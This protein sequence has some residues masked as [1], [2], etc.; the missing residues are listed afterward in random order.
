MD[1]FKYQ[2]ICMKISGFTLEV[3]VL[4]DF[5]LFYFRKLPCKYPF[6]VFYTLHN[7]RTVQVFLKNKQVKR[8]HFLSVLNSWFSIPIFSSKYKNN[9]LGIIP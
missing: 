7:N 3:L 8:V 4:R 1:H 6:S 2:C 9:K 5:Y